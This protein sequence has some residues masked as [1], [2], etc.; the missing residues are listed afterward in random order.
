[1]ILRIARHTNNLKE[2]IEFYTKVLNLE[3]LGIF[4]DHEGY[5]GVFIGKN[6]F[7]WHL[8]FT[9]SQEKAIHSFDE[10]DN[11]VFYPATENSFQKIM[12][13]IKKYKLIT[14]KAKNP[15]WNDNGILI[16]D[17]EGFNVIISPL[18]VSD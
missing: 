4:K 6:E 17:P 18:K 16:K 1:M 9:T 5:D 3:V 15:Y 12:E 11:L 13:N 10:D 8:E 7:E 14:Y 2:I